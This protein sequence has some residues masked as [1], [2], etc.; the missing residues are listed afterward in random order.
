M[1]GSHFF[2]NRKR[3]NIESAST[4][5][6]SQCTCQ[7]TNS[8]SATM[9][10]SVWFQMLSLLNTPGYN[11]LLSHCNNLPALALFL[12]LRH[13]QYHS[14]CTAIWSCSNY[15]QNNFIWVF[16]LRKNILIIGI[17]NNYILS[18]IQVT[19]SSFIKVFLKSCCWLTHCPQQYG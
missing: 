5:S 8:I 11:M 4:Q 7:H 14:C 18:T 6:Q 2:K 15:T 1:F 3:H 16:P 13:K 19:V 9:Q 17:T 10:E 12:V